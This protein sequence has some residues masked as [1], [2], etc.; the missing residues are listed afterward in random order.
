V[1]RGNSRRGHALSTQEADFIKDLIM[2]KLHRLNSLALS[3]ILIACGSAVSAQALQDTA[4]ATQTGATP[5]AAAPSADLAGQDASAAAPG[6]GQADSTP[7]MIRQGDNVLVTNG[8]IPDTKANRARFGKPESNAGK[9]T[10][11]A[12]N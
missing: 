8:P 2:T 12:G 1:I 6:D 10:A 7:M 11:P 9:K 3:A 5:S 4:P